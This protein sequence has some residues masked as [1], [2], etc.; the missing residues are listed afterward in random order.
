MD[1]DLTWSYLSLGIGKKCIF[2][3]ASSMDAIIFYIDIMIIKVLIALL[4]TVYV[5][6]L[7]KIKEKKK[8]VR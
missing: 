4:I 3:N 7:L 6:I 5:D 8:Q 1:C 2:T